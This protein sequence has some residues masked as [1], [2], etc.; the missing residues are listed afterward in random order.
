M[1]GQL[2]RALGSMVPETWVAE[3]ASTS[4]AAAKAT[5][6]PLPNAP[7]CDASATKEAPPDLVE[8]LDCARTLLVPVA[9]RQRERA[10]QAAAERASNSTKKKPLNINIPL[11]GPRLE[12]ILAWLAAVHLMEF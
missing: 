9:A 11:H 5:I 3:F 10:S 1:H 2:P 7:G 8:A 12:V 4:S 6:P